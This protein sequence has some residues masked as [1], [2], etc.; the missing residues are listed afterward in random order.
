MERIDLIELTQ[1]I[2]ADL[3]RLCGIQ[4]INLDNPVR[5]EDCEPI[6]GG[7]RQEISDLFESLLTN[8]LK[9]SEA[10]TFIG[11]RYKEVAGGSIEISI[12]NLG[13]EIGHRVM[14][15]KK[16]WLPIFQLGYRCPEAKKRDAGG[17]GT[18]L[19]IAR[20][21][22]ALHG[23]TI[24]LYESE[25]ARTREGKPCFRNTFRLIFPKRRSK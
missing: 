25:P 22:M 17:T 13:I 16:E 7:Y 19:W 24:D 10:G 5:V 2:H 11:T 9:Y 14:N 15:G 12:Q 3:C 1:R 4:D 23:G 6:I 20:Y 18:G 8:T 21:I